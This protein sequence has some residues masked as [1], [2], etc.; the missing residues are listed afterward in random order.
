MYAQATPQANEI[1]I[2]QGGSLASVLLSFPTRLQC[3]GKFENHSGRVS[4]HQP[5]GSLF[6]SPTAQVAAW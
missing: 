1:S 6:P 2:S 3:S 4:L 5:P